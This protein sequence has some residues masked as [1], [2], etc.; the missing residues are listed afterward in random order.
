[1]PAAARIT[2]MRSQFDIGGVRSVSRERSGAS[3]VEE[4][5]TETDQCL[6]KIAPGGAIFR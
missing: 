2:R 3:S 4:I 1:M 6:R 5:A